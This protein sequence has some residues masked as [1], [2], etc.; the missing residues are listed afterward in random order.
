MDAR[1]SALVRDADDF[2]IADGGCMEEA[3][4]ARFPA[5]PSAANGQRFDSIAGTLSCV[6]EQK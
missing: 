6:D 5:G 2:F 4:L 1:G 3:E